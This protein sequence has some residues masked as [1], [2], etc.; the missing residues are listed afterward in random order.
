MSTAAAANNLCVGTPGRSSGARVGLEQASP[1]QRNRQTR[2][3]WYTTNYQKWTCVCGYVCVGVYAGVCGCARVWRCV[4]VLFQA[5][6]QV[7]EKEP[8]DRLERHRLGGGVIVEVGSVTDQPALKMRRHRC[9]VPRNS[10]EVPN[11]EA[12]VRSER[13]VVAVERLT[14]MLEER[15]H[16]VD[17]GGWVS[18]QIESSQPEVHSSTNWHGCTY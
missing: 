4:L 13:R 10:G 18:D 16:G 7:D 6:S 2:V 3:E 9:L 15:V 5:D 1:G 12:H 14:M 17:S 8:A 11:R